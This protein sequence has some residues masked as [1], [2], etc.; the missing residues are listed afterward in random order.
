MGGFPI[1]EILDDVLPAI[2]DFDEIQVA[3]RDGYTVINYHYQTPE[4]FDQSPEGLIRCECRGLIF[5][6]AG[7]LISRPFHK[8]FNIGERQWTQSHLIDL[9]RSHLIQEKLDGSMVRPF[10]LDGTVHFATRAGIT[11]ISEQA[12]RVF[13]DANYEMRLAWIRHW[14]DMAYTPIFEYVSPSNRIVIQYPES[15]VVFLALRHNRTGEYIESPVPYPGPIVPVHHQG[16]VHGGIMEYI[17]S[18][19][20]SED[21]EGDVL[22]FIDGIRYKI[23]TAWYLELHR[24]RDEIGIDRLIASRAL[25][26]RLDDIL[27]VLPE[28]EAARVRK[29]GDDFMRAYRD[30]IHRIRQLVETMHL[31]IMEHDADRKMVATQFVPQHSKR[32]GKFCFIALDRKTIEEYFH[33][34]VLAGLGNN[35]KY[36]ELMKWL[37]E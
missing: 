33:D 34:E 19:H 29:V 18:V 12:H 30:K 10:F 17:E 25:S 6:N 5:D 9:S 13:C 27:V 20:A 37:K 22:T 35:T 2:K 26:G 16:T 1:I 28:A 24:L 14:M 32:D 31:W 3:E 23:K 8:F 21:R 4:T 36:T 7:R 15:Q 11:D